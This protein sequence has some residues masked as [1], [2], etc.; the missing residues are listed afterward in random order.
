MDL[1]L[2]TDAALRFL[3]IW[4]RSL[5]FAVRKQYLMRV[6]TRQTLLLDFS[7]TSFPKLKL[8]LQRAVTMF[9]NLHAAIKAL[10]CLHDHTR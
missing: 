10:L 6:R 5:A 3:T 9:V 2:L 1:G 8:E 4:R 7:S